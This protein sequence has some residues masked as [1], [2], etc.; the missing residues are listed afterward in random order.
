[1]PSRGTEN[2]LGRGLDAVTANEELCKTAEAPEFHT[3]AAS[4]ETG[5]PEVPRF[6]AGVTNPNLLS[7]A[8]AL[9]KIAEGMLLGVV[10]PH[11]TLTSGDEHVPA[12]QPPVA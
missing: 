7:K 12:A 5:A 3:N 11:T 4:D 8:D 6:G 2:V 10:L 9:S 1:M